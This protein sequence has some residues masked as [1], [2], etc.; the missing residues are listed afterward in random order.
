MVE[1]IIGAWT[2]APERRF[3]GHIPGT[4]KNWLPALANGRPTHFRRASIRIDLTCHVL[5]IAVCVRN[6]DV[7]DVLLASGG[8]CTILH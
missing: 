3:G 2:P 1:Q 5:L 6:D 8:P 7:A 4:P